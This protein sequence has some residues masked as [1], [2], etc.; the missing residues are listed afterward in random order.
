MLLKFTNHFQDMVQFRNINIEHVKQAVKSPD[1]KEVVFEGRIRV[2]KKVG[3][4]NIE[5][6]YC[7]DNFK[8]K[9]EEYIVITAYYI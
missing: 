4:K 2:Q 3:K 8:D 1:I 5:V 6:I 7:K 9:R